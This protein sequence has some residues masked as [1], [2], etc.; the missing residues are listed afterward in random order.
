MYSKE[1]QCR[2]QCISLT[3]SV[4]QRRK[5]HSLNILCGKWSNMQTQRNIYSVYHYAFD[6]ALLN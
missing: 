2:I 1:T 4:S 6:M 5:P 3:V